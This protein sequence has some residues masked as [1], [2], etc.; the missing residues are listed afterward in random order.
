MA[1]AT[2]TCS[3]DRCAR[4]KDTV[5]RFTLAAA[6]RG[7]IPLP[8][9][10]LATLAEATALVAAIGSIYGHPVNAKLLTSELAGSVGSYTV[11]RVILLEGARLVSWLAGPLGVTASSALCATSLA[12]QTWELGMLAIAYFERGGVLPSDEEARRIAAAAKA[13]LDLDALRSSH[14]DNP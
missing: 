2:P 13:D 7:A 10:A 14:Q 1:A 4:A 5:A 3:S 6:V 8:G 9:S 11:S 12:A